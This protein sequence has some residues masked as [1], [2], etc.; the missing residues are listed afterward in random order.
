MDKKF[1]YYFQEIKNKRI[2]KKF[3]AFYEFNDVLELDILK[4]IS[5]YEVK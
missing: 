4:K 1:E 3:V 2:K 5:N